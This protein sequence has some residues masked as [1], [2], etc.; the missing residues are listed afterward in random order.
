MEDV[1]RTTKKEKEGMEDVRR[2]T[3]RKRKGNIGEGKPKKIEEQMGK[4]ENG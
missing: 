2:S 3:K 1:K 4:K